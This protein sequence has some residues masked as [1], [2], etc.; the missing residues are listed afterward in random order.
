MAITRDMDDQIA[1][2]LDRA[3]D[4]NSTACQVRRKIEDYLEQRRYR[5]ELGDVNGQKKRQYPVK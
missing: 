1:V 3:E 5:D 2:V 4:G